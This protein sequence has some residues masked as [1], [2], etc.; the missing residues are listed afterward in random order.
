MGRRQTGSTQRASQ[1]SLSS[2]R[3]ASDG[4]ISSMDPGEAPFRTIGIGNSRAGSS[5]GQDSLRHTVR[6]CKLLGRN[7]RS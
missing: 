3:Q 2:V 6:D 7:E 4:G 1:T 5:G